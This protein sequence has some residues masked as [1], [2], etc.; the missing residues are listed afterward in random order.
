MK[1]V[2]QGIQDRP[3]VKK[4]EPE[5][6]SFHPLDPTKQYASDRGFLSND[7]TDLDEIPF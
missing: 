5:M 3:W 6:R 7:D 1:E 2:E 4:I